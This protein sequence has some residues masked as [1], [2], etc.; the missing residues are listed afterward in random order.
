MYGLV[1]FFFKFQTPYLTRK[2]PEKAHL[3]QA[4]I[5]NYVETWKVIRLYAKITSVELPTMMKIY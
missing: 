3:H 2:H 4:A 1:T 5:L